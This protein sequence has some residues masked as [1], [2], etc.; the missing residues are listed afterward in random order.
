MNLINCPKIGII[1]KN[2]INIKKFKNN[3]C[4]H[5]LSLILL[6]V[7]FIILVEYNL[8]VSDNGNNVPINILLAI[9]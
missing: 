2:V 8:F 6:I 1:D 4:A 3:N 7:N 9:S 5:I